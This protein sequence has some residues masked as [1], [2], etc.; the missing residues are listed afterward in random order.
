M[1]DH[2]DAVQDPRHDITDLYIFQKPGDSSRSVLILD[3][4][5]AAPSLA[6]AF[7]PEAS[8]EFKIDTNADAH[9][10]VAFHVL[11]TASGEGQQIATVYRAS[12]EAAHDSGRVGEVIIH[13]APVS[14]DLETR[15]T[16]EGAYR[17]YAG[18]RSDPF[19]VEPEGFAN[20]FQFTGHDSN[21]DKNVFGIVLEVP[22]ESLGSNPSI[23]IWARTMALLHG[24][25]HQM[26]EMARGSNFFNLTEEDKHRFNG[27]PP[28]QQRAI[29]LA[30]FVAVF[31]GFGYGEAEATRLALGYVPS[32][33]HYD[34]TSAAGYPNGRKLEDD[35]AD[36][37]VSVMTRGRINTDLVEPHTDF[38]KDFPYLG[39]PHQV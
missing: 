8:Y 13:H 24:T 21:L 37:A 11:F 2:F 12:G 29:F 1:A 10:E 19:F 6:T 34:Y 25:L 28:S 20:N 16:T 35:I 14:F 32:I 4:N 17:F 26:D 7:D 31:Q 30:K 33:L 38:L 36:E 22:S 15:V 39:P 3:V 23:G 18:L 27:T 5:P 9:A